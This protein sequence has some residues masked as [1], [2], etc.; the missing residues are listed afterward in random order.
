MELWPFFKETFLG[1]LVV[2]RK[3]NTYSLYYFFYI[4]SK[5]VPQNQRE[6]VPSLPLLL[7]FPENIFFKSKTTIDAVKI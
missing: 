2:N 5:K 4:S 7:E 1:H 6:K 3:T